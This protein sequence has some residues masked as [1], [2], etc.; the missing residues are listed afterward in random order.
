VL[1][2]AC[3]GGGTPSA[4][5]TPGVT[6]TASASPAVAAADLS[7]YAGVYRTAS[8]VVYL[9]S[10]SGLL[11]DTA[12]DSVHSIAVASPG[13]LSL[14]PSFANASPPA[15]TV[16]F[17]G[18][19]NGATPPSLTLTLAGGGT[20]SAAR[21]A[22]T[23]EDVHIRS[24]DVELAATLTRPAQGGRLPAI[25]IVH[26]SGRETREIL[27]LWTQL[28][29]SLGFATLTYDKRGVGESTGTYPG[30]LAS[31]DTLQ[32]LAGDA[33]AV[34]AY[35]RTRPDVDPAQ[36]SLYGGSQ[37]GW[38]LPLADALAHPALNVIVSG[39]P[40]TV[41]QQ[42]LFAS[43]SGGGAFLPTES[44]TSIDAQVAAEH[45]GYDPGPVLAADTVPTLWLFG[46]ADRH[47]PA[48]TAV[49]A[50][51]H[52]ARPTMSWHVFPGCSHNLLDTGTGL[53]RDD[54][55]ATHFGS[56]LFAA[57]AAFARQHGV[58]TPLPPSA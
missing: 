5:S 23:R 38:V 14:G 37:G 12:D 55:A 40:V 8:G 2:S 57:I 16:T 58:A 25:A 34:V 3:G 31:T 17:P 13:T 19:Q 28:Y 21:M 26:G 44:E 10:R 20:T 1:L 56:G 39:P 9:L 35:L 29:V 54:N 24:G 53:D 43:F 7:P 47:V 30:D 4:G 41:G 27:D 51:A 52:L 50:L 6:A 22:T 18:W 42:G 32:L 36:V 11:V 33:A 45:S 46:G 15:G 49:A 48:R